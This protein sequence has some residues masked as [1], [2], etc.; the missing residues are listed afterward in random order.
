MIIKRETL[1]K[2]DFNLTLKEYIDKSNQFIKEEETIEKKNNNKLIDFYK[3]NLQGKYFIEI[4]DYSS[5]SYNGIIKTLQYSIFIISDIKMKRFGDHFNLCYNCITMNI[6]IDNSFAYYQDCGKEEIFNYTLVEYIKSKWKELSKEKFLQLKDKAS[7]YND[8]RLNF[9]NFYN[10]ILDYSSSKEIKLYNKANKPNSILTSFYSEEE[11][12]KLTIGE[13]FS[14]MDKEIERQEESNKKYV[15]K[16]YACTNNTSYSFYF[17]FLT[18]A[19]RYIELYGT[20]DS[21]LLSDE[22][23]ISYSDLKIKEINDQSIELFILN[24]MKTLPL[25]AEEIK[26]L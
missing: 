1:N 15:G 8:L 18:D 25:I 14:Q 2:E 26:K 19:Y 17:I 23:K 12:K 24:R 4:V 10:Q 5:S 22:G 7:E 20:D 16:L 6:G 13:I 3:N 9:E 21:I 11:M